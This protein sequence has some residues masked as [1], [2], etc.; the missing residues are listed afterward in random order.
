MTI[1]DIVK[2]WDKEGISEAVKILLN[3]NTPLFGSM[4]RYISE[5]PDLKKMLYTML[6]Q[7]E[8]ISYNPDNKAIELAYMFGYTVNNTGS[9]QVANRIFE[10][11]LYNFLLSEEE[12][13]SVM[14]KM[15]KQDEDQF[16]FKGRLWFSSV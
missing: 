16:I 4:I 12:L 14:S 5:Y 8:R 15:A 6:F 10:T 7:G 11:R 1:E 13:S 9:V 2:V 3:E